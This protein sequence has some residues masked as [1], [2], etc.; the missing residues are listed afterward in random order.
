RLTCCSCLEETG[1]DLSKALPLYSRRRAP[2]A[3]DLVKLSR[4]FDRTGIAGLFGFIL[5][6]IVDSISHK[7]A[8]A[9]FAPNTIAFLQKEGFTFRQIR[10]RKLLDR[11]SQGLVFATIS[12]LSFWVARA[13]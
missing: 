4:G 7:L 1:D 2:E 12:G 9:I 5:P 3:K 6:L 11:F 13:V 8:P 10:L